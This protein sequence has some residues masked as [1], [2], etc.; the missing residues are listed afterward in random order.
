[1]SSP[2]TFQLTINRLKY[3]N[4]DVSLE[5]A[6]SFWAMTKDK[7]INVYCHKGPYQ[8]TF[9]LI[10]NNVQ[11]M[12]ECIDLFMK[13]TEMRADLFQVRRVIPFVGAPIDEKGDKSEQSLA[14]IDFEFGREADRDYFAKHASP[15][16]SDST[17]GTGVKGDNVYYAQFMLNGTDSAKNRIAKSQSTHCSDWCHRSGTA[18]ETLSNRQR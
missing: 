14:W 16:F 11:E 17:L 8:T 1:M 5:T 12:N 6:T 4:A 10:F 3:G 13:K 7:Q 15:L 18:F 2:A 9:R